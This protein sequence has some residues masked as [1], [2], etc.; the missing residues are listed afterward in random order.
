MIL[1]LV[2]HGEGLMLGASAAGAQT[3]LAGC[4]LAV[5]PDG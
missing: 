2:G 4:V 1:A 5:E 3:F